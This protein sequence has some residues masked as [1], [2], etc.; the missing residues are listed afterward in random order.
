MEDEA[1]FDQL[2]AQNI[3]DK[4]I[5]RI[6]D[7]EETQE[8]QASVEAAKIK[9][10]KRVKKK[11]KPKKEIPDFELADIIGDFQI[12]DHGNYIILRGENGELLD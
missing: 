7:V 10:P 8:D 4:V 6:S 9:K 3:I 11:F 12:D 5:D 2:Y 1:E